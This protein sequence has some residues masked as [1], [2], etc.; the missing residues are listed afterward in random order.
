MILGVGGDILAGQDG[1]KPSKFMFTFSEIIGHIAS[2]LLGGLA[3]A[4]ASHYLTKN[5]ER[6]RDLKLRQQAADDA[7]AG[8]RRTFRAFLV[9]FRSEAADR[10]HPP[11]TFA[12]FYQNKVPNLRHAADLVADDFR[13]ERRVQFDR[14]VSVAAGFTG[15][16]VE[17]PQADKGK[18]DLLEAIDAIIRF[19]DT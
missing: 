4:V 12:D 16:Q 11:N 10:H 19:M 8:R 18:K 1:Q 14:L 2:G 5:R 6:Q 9:Q 3:V 15:A 13:D 7:L 17:N